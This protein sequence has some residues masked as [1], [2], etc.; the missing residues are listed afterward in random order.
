MH[1]FRPPFGVPA[2]PI[3]PNTTQPQNPYNLQDMDLSF[4]NYATYLSGATPFMP[5]TFDYGQA[6][7]SQPSHQQVEPDV[8]VDVMPETQPEPVPEKSKRG[9]RSHKKKEKD[10]PRRTK[11]H[12]KW[13][14][15]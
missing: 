14:K 10:E 13:T 3:K 2:R 15:E 8:D 6:G 11:T 4:L 1:P 12:L 9:R 7:W 5:P